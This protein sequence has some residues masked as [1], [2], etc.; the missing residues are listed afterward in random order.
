MITDSMKKDIVILC[1]CLASQQRL[2]SYGAGAMALSFIDRLM[3]LGTLVYKASGL[4][5]T[6]RQHL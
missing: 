4:F 5:T 2:K 6:P 3:N 1:L